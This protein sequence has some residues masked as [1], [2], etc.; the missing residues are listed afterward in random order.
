[1]VAATSS[2]RRCLRAS[3]W[4]ISA[5][6]VG[7]PESRR[8]PEFWGVLVVD[9]GGGRL[10]KRAVV[11]RRCWSMEEVGALGVTTDLVTAGEILGMGRTKAYELVRA[12]AFPVPVARY[13]RRY[14]VAVAP[15]LRVLGVDDGGR[16]RRSGEDSA[17][18]S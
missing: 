13:G 1:M 16:S 4:L 9:R 18:D 6:S 12:G 3:V 7:G 11:R 17:D 5:T 10:V 2:S 14:V 15:I 8:G